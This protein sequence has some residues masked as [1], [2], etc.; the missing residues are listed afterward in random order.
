MIDLGSPGP[1]PSQGRMSV[2]DAMTQ[3][4]NYCKQVAQKLAAQR[5]A[6]IARRAVITTNARDCSRA[7]NTL[8]SDISALQR[9]MAEEQASF[10]VQIEERNQVGASLRAFSKRNAAL[11]DAIAA[12]VASIKSQV[13]RLQQDRRRYGGFVSGA[14]RACKF[15]SDI[16]EPKDARSTTDGALAAVEDFVKRLDSLL[17]QT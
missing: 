7:M 9:T 11:E 10:N 14:R 15:A 5:E 1:G 16:S 4:R 17:E 6:S 2:K 3:Q 13:L 12:E 8:A